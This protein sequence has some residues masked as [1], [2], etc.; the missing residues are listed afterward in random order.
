MVREAATA[1]S[2]V[3]SSFTV[4]KGAMIAETYAVFAAWDFTQTKKGNLDRLRAENYV[5]AATQT[6]LRDVAKVFNRRFDPAGRDRALAILASGGCA[7]EL[8]KPILLWHVTRDEFLLRDFLLHWLFPA[9]ASG[10]F[11]VRTEEVERYLDGIGARGG[12]TEHAWSPRTRT[13]VAAGL[14]RMAVDFG[15]LRG[16]VVKEFAAFHLPEASL[17]YLL[18]ALAEQVPNARRIID[19]PEWRMFLLHPADLERELLHLHQFRKVEYHAAGSL[20]QLTLPC[21][22]AAE[23]AQRMVG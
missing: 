7:L 15:L 13:R 21:A 19:S 12:E 6:W 5:G 2:H 3:V 20:V 10:A 8:W 23:Y 4:I 14:L 17:M 18:H 1:R 22:S 11:R 16:A 9:H